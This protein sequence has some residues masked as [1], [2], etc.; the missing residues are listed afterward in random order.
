MLSPGALA[1]VVA[2]RLYSSAAHR[3]AYRSPV[4]GGGRYGVVF[5]GGGPAAI[6]IVV[7]AAAD[8]RLDELLSRGVCIIE[9]GP[10]IGP[11]ALG[12]QPISANTRG[13]TFLRALETARAQSALDAVGDDPSTLALARQ[14][15][16]FPRLPLVGRHLESLG[17]AVHAMVEASPGCAVLTRHAVREVRLLAGG[18]VSVAAGHVDG[19]PTI[20]AAADHAVIAMGGTPRGLTDLRLLPGLGL[21]AYPDKLCH[22]AD[23]LDDRIGLPPR[24]RRAVADRRAAVVIGGSHSAWSA[25]WM[26]V[27]DPE[28]RDAHGRP[29]TVTVLHRSPLRF[30]F[31]STAR[32][33]AAGYAFDETRD[34][35]PRTGMVHRHG[36]LRA[37]AHALAWA[38]TRNGGQGPLRAIA[39]VDEPR[40][41]AAAEQAL[42]EAGAIIAGIGYLPNLPTLRWPD[43]SPLRLASDDNGALVTERARLLSDDGT[44]LPELLGLG[45]GAGL[46]ASGALAGEPAYA[47]RLDSVR[48]YQAEVGRIVLDS[49]LS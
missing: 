8:G 30:F 49:L 45:L 32:A 4:M 40:A 27:H 19:A 10:A 9:A 33:R 46:P 31:W 7:C 17:R 24:L 29:P 5:C 43:G 6:G 35:C 38:A 26:L 20:T 41:R 47:G 34:V 22:A 28:L 13:V 37:D 18:G 16:V 21:G 2:V 42:D 3:L 11:G 36:G 23:L 48:L 1:N 14:R 25:A 44:V 12:H 39:L 15:N